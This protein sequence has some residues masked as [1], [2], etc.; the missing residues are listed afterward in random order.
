MI[1]YKALNKQNG[2]IY[3][4]QTTSSLEI[5]R[6][7]HIREARS[8]KKVNT[9]FLNA[10][11]K[12]GGDGFYWT[13]IDSAENIDDLNN[14]EVKWIAHYDSANRDKGYNIELGG[15]NK[16]HHEE[17]KQK[18]GLQTKKDW[19]NPETAR[20]MM[21]GLKKATEVWIRKSAK[22]RITKKCIICNAEFTGAKHIT[23]VQNYCSRKCSFR[24][25]QDN[26]IAGAKERA[27][28]IFHSNNKKANVIAKE[29]LLESNDCNVKELI[30]IL[31]NRFDVED[32]RTVVRYLVGR[33]AKGSHKEVRHYLQL[34]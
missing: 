23:D 25:K 10:I 28:S 4:G 13:A 5:R 15:L 14:K 9:R 33:Q 30:D 7:S 1:I 29:W 24:D 26:M 22:E 3:I 8:K 6:G 2:K 12:Y 21:N 16:H 11:D 31:K 18:I 27:T 20:S 32:T 19:E 34:K 17:T